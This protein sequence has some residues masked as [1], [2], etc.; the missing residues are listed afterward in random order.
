[1]RAVTVGGSGDRAVVQLRSEADP[2]NEGAPSGHATLVLNG[3][4]AVNHG[5][6]EG[7]VYE[8]SY[9]KVSSAADD[10]V[11]ASLAAAKAI[12]NATNTRG[13]K[14]PDHLKVEPTPVPDGVV[15]EP[16]PSVV[17]EPVSATPPTAGVASAAPAVEAESPANNDDT[18]KRPAPRHS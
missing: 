14:T 16:R 6:E 17:L 3:D 11:V 8:F 1:M 7:G 2:A 18:P 13:Y 15:T 12:P 9:N 10:A 5:F 4:D